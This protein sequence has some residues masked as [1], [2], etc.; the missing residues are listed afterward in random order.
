MVTTVQGENN[1]KV[2]LVDDDDVAR[3]RGVETRNEDGRDEDTLFNEEVMEMG[4]SDAVAESKT[5]G[6]F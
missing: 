4:I 6:A 5:G 3:S 2:D 1:D